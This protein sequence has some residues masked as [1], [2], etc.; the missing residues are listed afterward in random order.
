[1]R[2]VSSVF[3]WRWPLGGGLLKDRSNPHEDAV[4][5]MVVVN[6]ADLFVELA[7]PVA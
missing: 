2:P 6:V 4:Q 5:V 7:G 3:R 1:M